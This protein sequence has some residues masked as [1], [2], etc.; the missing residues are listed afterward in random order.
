[1]AGPVQWLLASSGVRRV[2]RRTADWIDLAWWQL[3]EQLVT[4]AP[5]A[6]GRLLDVGCGE[7]PYEPI[8]RPYVTEYVGVEY[9]P[10]F[11]TTQ[12]SKRATGPDLYYDGKTLPFPDDS[13]DTVISIQ[14]LEHTPHPQTVVDEMSRVAK[15]GGLVLVHVPFSFRLHEEPNDFFRYTPHGLRSMFDGAGIE[16]EGLWP[17]GGLWSV[18]GHKLNSYLAYRVARA[19][20]LGQAMGKAGHEGTRVAPA[21]TW[22]L[23]AVVPA[24]TAISAASRVLDRLAPDETEALCYLVFGR[25][26]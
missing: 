5:R 12:S 15:K 18:V 4:F 8:F 16:V 17:M 22:T 20:A 10:V 23:P 7:K 21:R 11:E 3:H 13:F 26:R 19:G 2:A 9:A 24:M 14:V 6:S 25:K 1:M